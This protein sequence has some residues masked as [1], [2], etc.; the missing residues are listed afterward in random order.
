MEAG[1]IRI[2]LIGILFLL[3]GIAVNAQDPMGRLR[4]MGRGGS[5]GSGSGDSLQHR[6]DDTISINYRYLDSSR[7]LKLDSSIVDFYQRN[8]VP[9]TWIDLGNAGN[10]ARSLVFQ[11]FMKPGWDPGWHAY[12]P[13]IF[14]ADETKFYHTTKPYSELGYLIGNHLEQWIDLLHTRNITKNWNAMFEYRLI[15]S[16]GNFNNQNTNHNNY[17]FSSWYASRNK[18]Y[19]AFMVIVGSKL[20]SGENAGIKDLNNLHDETYRD[21]FTIPTNLG[22]QNNRTAESDPFGVQIATG[23]FYSL[24]TYMLRQQYDLIGKKDSIVTDS[25]VIPL[26]YP[27]FRAEHTFSYQT[28]H[29]RFLDYNPDTTYYI[30]HLNFISTPDTVRLGDTWHDLTNDLS[31]YS[32]PDAKNPQ[33]FLKLGATLQN[34]HGF[35]DAGERTLYNI[36]LHGEYRNKT[37]NR[38]WD[39]E[40]F[41]N[42]Y[43]AG[44]N[45]GDYNAYISLQRE[46]SKKLG[47]LQVGFENVNRTL[48]TAWNQESSFGFGVPGFF[49]KENVTHIFGSIFQPALRFKLSANYY[50]L[51]NY[52]YFTDYYVAAQESNPFNVLQLAGDK[53]FVFARHWVLR[54]HLVLQQRAG[55]APVNIP[56][57]VTNDQ[58]GY[59]GKFGF[60]NLNIAFGLEFRYYTPYK[61]DN[62]S[63]VVG[64]FFT[65][66][67]T[68]ISQKLP[69]INAYLNFRI[70]AFAV[71]VRAE[72]LNTAEISSAY[73]FGF[74]NNN[75]VAPDYPY[76]GF[77]L[78]IGI[79]WSFVN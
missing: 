33:Q 78:R 34:L 20:E 7:L 75:L 74:T 16:P 30:Q 66:N 49:N 68:T 59:E 67:Q 2:F 8:P 53:V 62:Y 14:T 31:V 43:L 71:Y 45:A 48:S 10:A 57:L 58:F 77:R 11:P 13:Y 70:R 36:S 64:Q 56:L 17:R 50:L 76:P 15:N 69:D 22:L 23:T 37:K 42:F 29:Y 54:A 41:G 46:I 24:G 44:Y 52:P 1:W 65:Q 3:L 35:Y 55:N 73:G 39:V 5:G 9:A 63:P 61:A 60:K 18:R 4:N 19:Q 40:A 27:R 72:N 12:D 25:T 38:K 32:F 79:Y 47:S 6:V 51:N 26:F 28:F 21:R